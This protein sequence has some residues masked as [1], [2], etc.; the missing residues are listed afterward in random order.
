MGSDDFHSS[1]LEGADDGEELSACK[2]ELLKS[3]GIGGGRRGQRENV[4]N[5][6]G[7]GEEQWNGYEYGGT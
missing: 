7:E 3:V 2:S 5:V 4:G 1:L 6:S